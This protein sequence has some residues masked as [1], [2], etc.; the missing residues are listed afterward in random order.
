[1]TQENQKIIYW[2]TI[3][4]ETYKDLVTATEVSVTKKY[5]A[6]RQLSQPS[7]FEVESVFDDNPQVIYIPRKVR[8]KDYDEPRDPYQGPP[9]PMKPHPVTGYTRK[10]EMTEKH[11]QELLKLEKEWEIEF[12]KNI[13]IG[14]TYV[15]PHFSPEGSEE[16]I[17]YFPVFIKKRIETQLAQSLRTHK[18]DINQASN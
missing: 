2:A 8:I 17:R 4:A 5:R 13:P 12:V 16:F 3:V 9:R 14:K 6:L 18:D 7:T 11:R 1:M 10:G 15:R